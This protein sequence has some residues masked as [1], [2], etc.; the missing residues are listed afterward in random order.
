RDGAR[1]AG[2]GGARRAFERRVARELA[3]HLTQ[4]RLEE[5][6]PMVGPRD[7][8]GHEVGPDEHIADFVE[9]VEEPR[10]AWIGGGGGGRLV[11][12]RRAGLERRSGETDRAR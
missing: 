12:A 6:L 7:R 1:R 3:R 9:V 11:V 4:D 2:F 5:L 8:H 10:R